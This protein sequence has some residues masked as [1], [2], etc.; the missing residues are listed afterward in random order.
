LRKLEIE[1]VIVSFD[2]I[3]RQIVEIKNSLDPKKHRE[4]NPMEIDAP[5]QSG[6]SVFMVLKGS[7]ILEYPCK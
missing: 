6:S 3:L 5:A 2:A 1:G 4:P 7:P